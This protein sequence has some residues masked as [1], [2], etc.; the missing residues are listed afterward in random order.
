M[1]TSIFQT[2]L[3]V[4][5]GLAF[6]V[7]VLIFAG[8]LPGFRSAQVG[9]EATVLMWGT[10]DGDDIADLINDINNKAK[11]AYKVD[12]VEK[13]L[14]TLN[15]DLLEALATGRGPDLILLPHELLFQNRN[16]LSPLPFDSFSERQFRDYFVDSGL[17]FKTTEGWLAVPVAI[18]PLVL[19]YNKDIYANANILTPPTSWEEFV[20]NQ[21]KLTAFDE[22]RNI[23]QSAVSFGTSN[24]INNFKEILSLLM[25]QVGVS[26]IVL[27]SKDNYIVGLNTIGKISS[28][29]TE[30]A[31]S[32]YGQFADLQRSTYTWNRSLPKDT[33]FFLAGNLANYF[34]LASELSYVAERNPHLNFDVASVPR[35]NKG[36]NLTV[37]RLYGLAVL[38]N[39]TKQGP[40]FSAVLELALGS[41]KFP[42]LN[43][44]LSLPPV[45]RASL[46]K[47]PVDDIS[48]QVFYREALVCR[49]WPDPS[50]NETGK[51]FGDLVDNV[52]TGR[53]TLKASID[54]AVKDLSLI[55]A[56]S[57]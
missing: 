38:K 2:I 31:L 17:V 29:D 11:E 50:Y 9:T 8:V 28:T 55:I 33:E 49:V 1:K 56:N 32:F 45:L 53:L 34:G 23:K 42:E 22:L 21:P 30:M 20:L 57:K 26:P 10:I 40:A 16:K 51:V 5:L 41:H 19:Y 44:L 6:G 39:S 13:N 24:N 43:S 54:K 25:M 46:A 14:T 3:L 27:D 35:L 36:S 47:L 48:G 4:F 12:Y 7:G 37:G 18:D 15:D 52:A